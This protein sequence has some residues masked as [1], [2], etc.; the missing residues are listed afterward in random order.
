MNKINYIKTFHDKYRGTIPNNREEEFQMA[1]IHA[2]EKV[3]AK[4]EEI[5]KNIRNL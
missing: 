2:I 5:E 4:L 1:T 3:Y